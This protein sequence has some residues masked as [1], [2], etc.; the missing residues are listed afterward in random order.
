[1][2]SFTG[3][4]TG[5]YT[6][7]VS[8]T[9]G[10]TA[11]TSSLNMIQPT[12]PQKFSFLGSGVNTLTCSGTLLL[13][14][15]YEQLNYQFYGP[16]IVST[17]VSTFIVNQPGTYTATADIGVCPAMAITTVISNT[18]APG[19]SI[20][21]A[22]VTVC[23]QTI[24]TV[25]GSFNTLL[26][27]TGSTATT[28]SVNTTGTYSVTAT[29]A[30]ECTATA[31]TTITVETCFAISSSQTVVCSQS[32]IRLTATGCPP[33]AVVI[34]STGDTGPVLDITPTLVGNTAISV[35]ITAT[36]CLDCG[37]T[38]VPHRATPIRQGV[39]PGSTVRP[40]KV[41]LIPRLTRQ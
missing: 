16:G 26:W 30:N 39:G 19:I 24:L 28:L 2:G 12:D 34:W 8:D 41:G 17:D 4:A 1:M 21:P 5:V 35:S 22:N 32:T 33:P 18:A 37:Q 40:R 9:N 36:C 20:S 15:R 6:I 3:L 13:E 38:G 27:N 10:C 11:S 14:T 31:M 25:S 23:T 7:R 29:G